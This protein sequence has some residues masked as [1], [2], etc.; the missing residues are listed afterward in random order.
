[1]KKRRRRTLIL[2]TTLL[3]LV[4]SATA[5]A[6]E[7]TVKLWIQGNYVEPDVPPI[8]RNDRTLVPIR[9]IS[10][11]LGY[12]VQ[13]DESARS[14][15]IMKVNKAAQRIDKSFFMFI[16][17]PFIFDIDTDYMNMAVKTPELVAGENELDH[18][19]LYDLDVAPIIHNDRTMV[20]L[21]A[22]SEHLDVFV[23]WD[24][25]NRTAI[26]GEGYIP[27]TDTTE[28][29]TES[30]AYGKK[31]E[32]YYVGHKRSKVYHRPSCPTVTGMKDYNKVIL[33]DGSGYKPCKVC[34]P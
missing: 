12:N 30:Y 19:T 29:N 16:D 4:F 7:P 20:P 6:A 33:K 17:Q 3:L 22:I 27:P 2:M 28:K 5:S 25:K 14:V 24:E 15:T 8:I 23:D 13:W 10:E 34:T 11:N 32:D 1:M 26:V 9:I 18:I 31:P 21:R